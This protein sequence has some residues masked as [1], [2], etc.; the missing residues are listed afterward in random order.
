MATAQINV[1]LDAR[2][3]EAGD[4]ALREVGTSPSEIV[5]ALWDKMAQRGQA[6]QD[7][8]NVLYAN[9]ND[10]GTLERERKLALVDSMANGFETFANARGAMSGSAELTKEN[11]IDWHDAVWQERTEK[12]EDD[13]DR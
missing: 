5:R 13:G 10:E 6:L 2:R 11:D 3:K 8:M 9:E 7:V 12:W 1:R 4:A